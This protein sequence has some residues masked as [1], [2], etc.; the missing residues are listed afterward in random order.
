[1]CAA[2]RLVIDAERGVTT[3]ITPAD[4]DGYDDPTWHPD[5]RRVFSIAED[6]TGAVGGYIQDIGGGEPTRV[7][8]GIDFTPNGVRST[9][10]GGY[11]A[12]SPIRKL[13]S[14]TGAP[15]KDIPGIAQ[16]ERF[17]CAGFSGDGREIFVVPIGSPR[18]TVLGIDLRT[19][20]RRTIRTISP[21][22]PAGILN[23]NFVR[24]SGDGKA[25]VYMVTRNL[26]D[27][28]VAEGLR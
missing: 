21:R 6:T 11:V 24:V 13:Y 10:D 9:R 12:V 17:F 22:N 3:A 4:E 28:Y 15:A 5:G 25:Y 20:A 16:E 1:L 2:K 26:S 19:G 18:P 23:A 27:I 7:L 8:Q 14:L